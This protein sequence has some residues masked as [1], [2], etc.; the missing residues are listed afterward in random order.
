M[1][2][3]LNGRKALILGVAPTKGPAKEKSTLDV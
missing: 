3:R 1:S 2:R